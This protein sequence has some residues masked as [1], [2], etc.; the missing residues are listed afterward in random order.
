MTVI[1][2]G[3]KFKGTLTKRKVTN[4][5]ILHHAAGSGDVKSI[6]NWH[7]YGNGWLGIAYHFYV[8]RDGTVY[9]GRP[10]DTVGGHTY[11]KNDTS[12]GVCFEGNFEKEQMSDVQK[13]AGAQLVT[14]ILQ[15]YPEIKKVSPHRNYSVTACPGRYFPFEEIAAGEKEE[16]EE[17]YTLPDAVSSGKAGEEL[18]L[19]NEFLYES[20]YSKTPAGAR[21]GKFY[22]WDDKAINGKIKITNKPENVGKFGQVTGWITAPEKRRTHKVVKG[23]TLSAL[24][25]RY[26][27]TVDEIFEANTYKFPTMT[28][29]HIVVGWV[30]DIPE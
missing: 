22:R 5:L 2:V 18:V 3:L 25:V 28:K 8:R 30:L 12:I 9:K 23:D 11:G 15:E 20:A 10:I 6:H 26:G 16:P 13:T 21:S 1:D 27:C 4:E 19:E 17:E 29:N 24:A 14:Y 7:I